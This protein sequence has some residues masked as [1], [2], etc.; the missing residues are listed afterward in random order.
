MTGLRAG[1]W[2]CVKPPR[3]FYCEGCF[4]FLFSPV[5]YPPTQISQTLCSHIYSIFCSLSLNFLSRSSVQLC[6]LV[7]FF[8][9]HSSGPRGRRVSTCLALGWH[10]HR[11]HCAKSMLESWTRHCS[12]SFYAHYKRKNPSIFQTLVS[13][14]RGRTRPLLVLKLL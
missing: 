7:S 12:L 5:S 14:P 3:L 9:P 2:N 1:A 4:V 8:L 11:L 13:N 6:N 10:R